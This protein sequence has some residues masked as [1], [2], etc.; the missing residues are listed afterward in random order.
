MK[1]LLKILTLPIWLP[2]KILW[3][4]S[5]VLAYCVFFIVLAIVIYAAIHLL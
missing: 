4:A 2:F 5:K 1:T 3:L